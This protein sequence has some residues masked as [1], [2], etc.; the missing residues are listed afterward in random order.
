M[1][2]TKLLDLKLSDQQQPAEEI[3]F[4]QVSPRALQVMV[5]N[6]LR[7][8]LLFQR[9]EFDKDSVEEKP[10]APLAAWL[11]ENRDFTRQWSRVVIIHDC[12]QAVL[13]PAVLYNVDNGKE[14]LDVQ[15]GDLF[16]G[17]LL[18][19]EINGRQD[20]S[21]Y[22]IPAETFR[23]LAAANDNIQH[24][25]LISL[26]LEWLDKI[27]AYEAGEVFVLF[28]TSHI[29]LAVRREEWQLVQPYEYQQPEDISYYLLSALEHTG[30]DPEK[31]QLYFNGWINTDSSLYNELIKYVA[32]IRMAPVPNGLVLPEDQLGDG[33]AHY[34]TPLIQMASCVL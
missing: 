23:Q 33:Q 14:L 27:P 28:E 19:D 21:V 32:D 18:A 29:Y 3:L 20:Y 17:A 11:H 2:Y 13:V 9:I 4:L 15:F 34:F 8:P 16:K 5:A 26:W 10:E 1:S 6:A 22:R 7:Q 24:R 25:H 30:L 31:I 12:A